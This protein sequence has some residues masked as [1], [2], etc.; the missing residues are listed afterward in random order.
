MVN[1]NDDELAYEMV[2]DV[3]R[4]AYANGIDFGPY[5]EAGVIRSSSDHTS[6]AALQTSV[7]SFA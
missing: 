4:M 3:C 5:S 1:T 2:V 7:C 6:L